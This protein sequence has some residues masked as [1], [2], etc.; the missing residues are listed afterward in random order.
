[1]GVISEAVHIESGHAGEPLESLGG[2]KSRSGRGRTLRHGTMNQNDAAV[3]EVMSDNPLRICAIIH[4]TGSGLQGVYFDYNLAVALRPNDS[5]QIDKDF[6]WT[7]SVQW[8][9]VEG[10]VVGEYLEVSIIE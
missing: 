10:G 4:N 2:V 7:G 1:M 8:Y 3:T 5:F 9:A 6:P